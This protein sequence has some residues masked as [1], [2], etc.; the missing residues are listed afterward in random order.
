MELGGTQ[1]ELEMVNQEFEKPLIIQQTA[2]SETILKRMS[3]KNELA[4]ASILHFALHGLSGIGNSANDNSLVVTEP[5]D[6]K[7]DG[8]LQ[9]KEIYA[10]N[11][12]ARLACLSA[13]ETAVG[14]PNDDGSSLSMVTAFFVAGANSV[15]GTNWKISDDATSLFIQEFYKQVKQN[16]PYPEALLN[17]RK[18]F[19]NG[20]FGEAFKQPYYWASF[21]YYGY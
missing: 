14:F 15:I 8:L 13:C 4:D 1:K 11:L 10:L 18:S 6:G 19:I 20:K 7:E 5:D 21:K 17:V 12:S 2:L 9:F 16:V 3:E